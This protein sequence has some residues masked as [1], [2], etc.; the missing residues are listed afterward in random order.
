MSPSA[1]RVGLR[2]ER[3]SAADVDAG[4]REAWSELADRA[5]EPNP[6][7]RPEFVLSSVIERGDEVELLVVRDGARWLAALPY[8]RTPR[9]RRIPLPT[10]NQWLPEYGYLANPLV[11]PDAVGPAVD[12]LVRT[13]VEEPRAAILVLD[14]HDPSGP[15]ATA[16]IA[17]ARR[18][19]VRPVVYWDFERA[20]W[21]R[22]PD[23]G[24]P[25]LTI[26]SSSR[27]K[28]G[29]QARRLGRALGGEPEL[30]DRSSEPEMWEAFLAMENSGWKA[31]TGAPI[32]ASA[33]DAAFF[34]AMCAGL[35]ARGHLRLYALQAG[36]RTVAMKVALVERQTLYSFRIA[37]DPDLHGHSPGSQ[38]QVRTFEAYDA[39]G[40]DFAD[41]CAAP[42]NPA[43][44][45]IY[46]DRRRLQVLLLPT[47]A[48]SARLLRPGLLAEA[49]G[50]VA[51]DRV[52]SP[53]RAR[54]TRGG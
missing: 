7:L 28:L 18:H 40:I 44:N 21:R 9:W 5:V 11:D 33:H 6:F 1:R 42:G 45:R 2:A 41:S 30:V 54:L 29:R 14:Q 39:E 52:V 16:L 47:G 22:R 17:A 26:S 19:G 50:R 43:A 20:A 24:P 8:R 12:A 23:G 36:G 31:R 4:G 3:F 51:R 10:L 48:P 46:P 27:R 37:Y 13:V 34:R 38:L 35:S 32:A 49:G 25:K 15:V 53:L